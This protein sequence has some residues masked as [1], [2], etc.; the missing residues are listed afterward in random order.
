TLVLCAFST[1]WPATAPPSTPSTVIAFL[2]SPL[3]NWWPTTPPSAP[4]ATAP[5]PLA[6]VSVIGSIC[7]TAPTVDGGAAATF[8]SFTGSVAFTG[9]GLAGAGLATWIGAGFTAGLAAGAGACATG[10]GA[11]AAGRVTGA[12]CVVWLPS[13]GP[14]A[15][16]RAPALAS[17]RVPIHRL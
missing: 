1:W 8:T 7:V 15:V 16:I 10:A 2:P 4:P 12:L 9:I 13:C 6:L 3:P 17:T 11:G 14:Q 5:T